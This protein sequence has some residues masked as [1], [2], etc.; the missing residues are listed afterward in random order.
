MKA[1]AEIAKQ[2]AENAK[3]PKMSP[4][5]R[6]I[7]DYDLLLAE[8]TLN[9]HKIS[10]DAS[11]NGIK[12]IVSET[13]SKY[14]YESK[15]KYGALGY[16]VGNMEYAIDTMNK[17]IKERNDAPGIIEKLEKKLA[18]E[19]LTITKKREIQRQIDL[20]KTRI[21]FFD[22][23]PD[24]LQK[25]AYGYSINESLYHGY[26]L[27]AATLR[28]IARVNDLNKESDK[29]LGIKVID[30]DAMYSLLK[31]KAN[32]VLGTIKSSNLIIDLSKKVKS[33]DEKGADWVK[34][35]NEIASQHT[36]EVK[37]LTKI[38]RAHV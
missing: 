18:T 38:G 21:E 24:D 37:A 15:Y 14:G 5:E 33:D 3:I 35:Y 28:S 26:S 8:S 19:K 31:E 1:K 13:R 23:T 20:A 36:E 29:I 16:S 22:K 7:L 9:N 4:D 34:H 10:I 30:D 12:S 6:K 32:G 25:D 11:D 17:M 27:H 2:A